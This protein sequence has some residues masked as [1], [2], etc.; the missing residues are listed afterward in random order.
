MDKPRVDPIFDRIK[1]EGA[2]A[3]GHAGAEF[4]CGTAAGM[5][6]AGV[7]TSE[8][9]I[10]AQAK[11]MTSPDVDNLDEARQNRMG[12]VHRLLLRVPEGAAG[13]VGQVEEDRNHGFGT[14]LSDLK[15]L[16]VGVAQ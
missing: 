13:E 15:V 1:R 16:K 9:S 4:G 2:R 14:T 7:E 12:E 6:P 8:E 10:A 5:S 11:W 3:E